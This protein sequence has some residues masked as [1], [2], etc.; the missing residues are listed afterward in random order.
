MKLLYVM[1]M[2]LDTF[3]AGKIVNFKIYHIRC[4]NDEI[5]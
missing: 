2:L 3:F 1:Q 4:S 5:I